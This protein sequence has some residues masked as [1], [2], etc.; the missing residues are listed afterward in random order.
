MGSMDRLS[1]RQG[2]T[3]F[4]P[5][6][7]SLS[8]PEDAHEHGPKRS[9]LLAVDQELAQTF[10]GQC[11]VTYPETT[12]LASRSLENHDL[13]EGAACLVFVWPVRVLRTR[14]R[15]VAT[16]RSFD[17]TVTNNASDSC[18]GGCLAGCRYQRL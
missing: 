15:S 11:G 7:P 3:H 17:Q 10:A 13:I 4:R 18:P 14:T 2:E 12:L 5:L 16:I 8:L 9:V 1:S 6:A